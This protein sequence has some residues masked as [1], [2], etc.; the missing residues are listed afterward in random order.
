MSQGVERHGI[1]HPEVDVGVRDA[2]LQP[3]VGAKV[4]PE[5]VPQGG[6]ILH[7][8]A[9]STLGQHLVQTPSCNEERVNFIVNGY[10]LSLY[11][12]FNNHQLDIVEFLFCPCTPQ[13]LPNVTYVAQIWHYVS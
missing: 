3:E 11:F 9:H 6:D 12:S 1:V 13:L 5:P 2:V 10:G 7:S 8:G 4:G